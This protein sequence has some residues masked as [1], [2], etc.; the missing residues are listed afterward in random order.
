[1]YRHVSP[2][3]K[4]IDLS[5]LIGGAGAGVGGWGGGGAIRTS[6]DTLDATRDTRGRPEATM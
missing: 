5:G 6:I 4:G 1:M 2:C 3:I